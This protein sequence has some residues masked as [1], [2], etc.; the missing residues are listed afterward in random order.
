MTSK[1]VAQL[2]HDL[3]V[4]RSFTRPYASNGII[5]GKL[6][7][8]SDPRWTPNP[9]ALQRTTHGRNAAQIRLD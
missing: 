2:P 3:Q 9:N 8:E 5:L 7:G 4:E 6:N 1:V